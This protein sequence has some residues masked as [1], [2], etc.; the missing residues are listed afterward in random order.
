M[1][2]SDNITLEE[3]LQELTKWTKDSEGL[4]ATDIVKKT[5]MSKG[6]VL[7]TL[8]LA[9]NKG[10]LIVGSKR[11]PRIDGRAGVIPVYRLKK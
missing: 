7:K 2:K 9:H 1:R 5:G 11:A 3:W 4:S 10:L 8:M 6:W